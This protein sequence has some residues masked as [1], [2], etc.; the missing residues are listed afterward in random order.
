MRLSVR[1]ELDYGF[2]AP[3]DL[4]LQIEAAVI[5]EQIVEESSLLLPPCAH[6]ARVAAQ[7]GIGE[8]IW[9][10]AGG[11]FV[12]TYRATVTIQRLLADIVTLPSVPPHMLPGE[13]V[14]YLMPSRFC[15]SD[16]FRT[17]VDAE[18]GGLEGGALAAAMRDWIAGHFSYVPGSSQSDT[19]AQDSFVSRQGICRDYAHTLITF[20]RAAAIPA[21]Y[22]S[23]YAPGVE[24]PDF[25]AV[26]ELFLGGAWHLVDA[27]G[28]AMEGTMAKIGVGRDAADVAIL[29]A[30]GCAEMRA[31]TVTVE[32]LGEAA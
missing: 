15:P 9:I 17:F 27:T 6:V 14:A 1:A 22:A 31:Q 16:R 23:V 20:A 2:A 12:A 8:R 28:M 18:F 32:A 21:R 30:Y 4:L 11:R 24:P 29:T 25:H 26:A 7:D 3:T 5:P 19:T 10:R 13:T